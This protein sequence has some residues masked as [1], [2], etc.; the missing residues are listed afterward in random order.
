MFCLTHR[1]CVFDEALSISFEKREFGQETLARRR[2]HG[3][4]TYIAKQLQR[5]MHFSMCWLK[6]KHFRLVQQ[7][8]IFGFIFSQLERIYFFSQFSWWENGGNLHKSFFLWK[9]RED[10]AT[11]YFLQGEKES[12]KHFDVKSSTMSKVYETPWQLCRPTGNKTQKKLLD[13]CLKVFTRLTKMHGCFYFTASYFFGGGDVCKQDEKCQEL[14]FNGQ[15]FWWNKKLEKLELIST[16]F[17]S[18]VKWS[19]TD[20]ETFLW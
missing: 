15:E 8:R 13:C 18:G 5:D 9:K 1:S 7:T 3:Y 12:P 10:I 17:F 6:M 4:E 16:F 14:F 19:V 20:L 11:L 2:E